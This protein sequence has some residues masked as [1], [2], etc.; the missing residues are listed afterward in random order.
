MIDFTF[1]NAAGKSASGVDG[2]ASETRHHANLAELDDGK[3]RKYVKEFPQ[4]GLSQ[5]SSPTIAGKSES[6]AAAW[7]TTGT[8]IG[9]REPA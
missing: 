4:A 9:V 3:L 6:L 5:E 7:S 1:T 8:A 2:A